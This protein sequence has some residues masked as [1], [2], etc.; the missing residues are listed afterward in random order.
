M[1]WGPDLPAAPLSEREL[2]APIF[3]STYSESW[4]FPEASPLIFKLAMSQKP[5]AMIA[6]IDEQR[7]VSFQL[8]LFQ[9]AISGQSRPVK[10]PH[11][12]FDTK[13]AFPS[14]I[15]KAPTG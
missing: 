3:C 14:N 6:L 1:K 9:F 4:K 2:V 13:E 7:L 10:Q 12:E 15:P 8:S 5:F 11:Q